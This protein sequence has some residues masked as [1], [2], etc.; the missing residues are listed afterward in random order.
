MSSRLRNTPIDTRRLSE[1]DRADFNRA[2]GNNS[3]EQAVSRVKAYRGN[4]ARNNNTPFRT[5]VHTPGTGGFT[6]R[7]PG[8]AGPDYS[9]IARQQLR[10]FETSSDNRRMKSLRPEKIQTS[11][12]RQLDS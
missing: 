5:Q 6:N 2:G 4:V 1:R 11:N 10:Q 8:Y 7:E 9:G 12:V 3:R